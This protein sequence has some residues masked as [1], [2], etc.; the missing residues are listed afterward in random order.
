V[1]RHVVGIRASTIVSAVA[2]VVVGSP[3][4]ASVAAAGGP[5]DVTGQKYGDASSALS[6]AGFSPVVS[7]TVGD[8]KAW[9]DCLVTFVQSHDASPP[10]NSHGAVTHQALVSLNCDAAAA[11]ATKPGYSAQSPQAR[12]IAKANASH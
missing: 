8:R 12:A 6:N 1:A 7:T 4:L 5:P 2:L 11:S 10:P 9:S 3:V